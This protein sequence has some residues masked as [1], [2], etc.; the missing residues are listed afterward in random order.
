MGGRESETGGGKTV[1]CE[2]AIVRV[3]GSGGAGEGL[4]GAMGFAAAETEL[5]VE[6]LA[7]T[8]G[9]ESSTDGKRT[10]GVRAGEQENVGAAT[11]GGGRCGCGD[12]GNG[13]SAEIRGIGIGCRSNCDESGIRNGRGSGVESGGG[14]GAAI[15]GRTTGAA[16]TPRNDGVGGASHGG[17][18]LL[19]GGNDDVLRFGIDDDGNGFFAAAQTE[20]VFDAFDT[21]SRARKTRQNQENCG[22]SSHAHSVAD[23][24]W[25]C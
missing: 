15:L 7:G 6:E 16:D 19:D 22:E 9:F 10:L 25:V 23:A 1:G 13:S 14:D 5:A 18:E 8:V 3:G 4:I 2:G 11:H 21:A 12:D 17:G 24:G 20:I